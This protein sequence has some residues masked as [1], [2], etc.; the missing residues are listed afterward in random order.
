MMPIGPLM[1]EHRLIERMIRLFA[2]E[3]ETIEKENVVDLNFIETAVDFIQMYA[4]RCH[5]GKEEDILFK[6][7]EKKEITS[8]HKKIMSELIEEHKMARDMVDKLLKAKKM[9]LDGNKDAVHIITENIHWLIN[10]YPE[11]ITKEDKRFFIPVMSYFTKDEQK[12]MLDEF[13]G[14]DKSLIHEKYTS[15]VQILENKWR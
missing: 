11:H 14:F 8:E 10:F 15:V 9:Y 7:L 2:K 6:E 1:T 12:S 3:L 5:H 13:W 4:D